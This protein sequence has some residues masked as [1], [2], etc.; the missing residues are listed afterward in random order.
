M[1][2]LKINCSHYRQDDANCNLKDGDGLLG[3]LTSIC[4]K[5]ACAGSECNELLIDPEMA[6]ITDL[7]YKT[8]GEMS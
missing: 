6:Q 5:I 4:I 8:G 1:S 3:G 7:F 2:F